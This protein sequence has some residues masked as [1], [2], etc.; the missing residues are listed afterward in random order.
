MGFPNCFWSRQCWLWGTAAIRPEAS[1]IFHASRGSDQ[2]YHS[3]CS[4]LVALP[5]SFGETYPG[6]SHPKDCFPLAEEALVRRSAAEQLQKERGTDESRWPM[7]SRL[8]CV[9]PMKQR[10]ELLHSNLDQFLGV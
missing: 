6:L 5:G 9:A 3:H 10:T 7:S 2:V 1:E 4:I 8:N